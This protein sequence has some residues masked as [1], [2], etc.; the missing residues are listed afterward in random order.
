MHGREGNA[1]QS[2][3]LINRIAF[4]IR[5]ALGQNGADYKRKCSR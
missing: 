4:L 2:T 1:L 5:F 3:F